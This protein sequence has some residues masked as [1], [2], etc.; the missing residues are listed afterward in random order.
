MALMKINP[1]LRLIRF[2]LIAVG[3]NLVGEIT[4][5]AVKNTE[6]TQMPLSV[7]IQI[8]V[9]L[10]LPPKPI[11]ENYPMLSLL[12]RVLNRLASA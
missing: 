9:V 8:A 5:R 1:L 12:P 7:W 6:N 2:A 11:Y 3:D 10:P 4:L